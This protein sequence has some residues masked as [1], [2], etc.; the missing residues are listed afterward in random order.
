MMNGMRPFA[1]E[2]HFL[3]SVCNMLMD[4]LDLRL[5]PIFSATTRIMLSHMT[6]KHLFSA[7]DSPQF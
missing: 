5:V 1:G 6:S 2:A 4:G 7:V 3:V